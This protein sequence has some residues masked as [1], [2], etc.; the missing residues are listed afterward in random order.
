MAA[1]WPEKTIMIR[2]T[3]A[4]ACLWL[5]GVSLAIAAEGVAQRDL[6]GWEIGYSQVRT[7]LP[8]GRHAN[9]ITTRAQCIAA[10]GNAAPRAIAPELSRE[11]NHWTQ[12]AGWSPDGRYAIV[13]QGYE[14]PENARWEE[15]HQTF[16]MTEGWRLDSYLVDMATGEVNNLSAVERVSEYNAGLYFWPGD[17]KTLGFEALIGG[18]SHP[19]RM[20][21]DGRNKQ[22]LAA[23]A[24][25]FIYGSQASPDGRRIASHRDYQIY[26][27]DAD[28]SQLQHIPT[29]KPFNFCPRWSP[30]GKWLLFVS[31]EHYDCHP[32]V[33]RPDGTE[34]HQLAS[35]HGYRG[36][37][38]FL[39][40]PD[41]HGGS[42]DVP[43]WHPQGNW[44]YYTAQ[45]TNEGD[46]AS[47]VDLYRVSL[48]GK[49]ERM[50]DVPPGRR[51]YH[52]LPSPDGKWL[53]FGSDSDGARALY[54]VS[55][56]GG[57]P[58]AVTEST[59][60][61]ASMWAHWRPRPAVG[62]AE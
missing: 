11:P 49:I 29:G 56:A 53:L 22:D 44:V 32:W 61:Q 55:A 59:P 4:W 5:C 6:S 14:D 8:G 46:S 48:E 60:G 23:D 39:D 54:V 43:V 20:D 31:G 21:R 50:V 28:G 17:P 9:V 40:V 37:I 47:S 38:D 3:A 16:R 42:S 58:L 45:S 24:E 7:N 18:K 10:D 62:A 34:L 12:F 33:V 30:D 25:Q 19:F 57:S 26:L 2:C 51:C 35:R 36:V 1:A 52:P 15:E 13:S 41:F 27:A